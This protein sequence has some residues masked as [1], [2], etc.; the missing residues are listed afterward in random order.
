MDKQKQIE[1]M[2]K[3]IRPVLENRVDIGFIPDLAEPIAKELLKHYQPKL[4]QGS[5]VLSK[6]EYADYLWFKSVIQI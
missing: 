1:E 4:P 6:E 3:V 5:V 2:A